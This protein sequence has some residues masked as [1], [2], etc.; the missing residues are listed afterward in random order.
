MSEVCGH[1]RVRT[2]V[3]VRSSLVSSLSYWSEPDVNF[4]NTFNNNR[5]FKT[6]LNQVLFI[7][8]PNRRI[9]LF[10]NYQV[11]DQRFKSKLEMEN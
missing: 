5:M 6:R 11:S 4:Q 1:A 3:L 10:R 9:F 2:R 8:S 7:Y